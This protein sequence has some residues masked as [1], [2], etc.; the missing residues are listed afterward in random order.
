MFAR[1]IRAGSMFANCVGFSP[2]W[3]LR[4]VSVPNGSFRRSLRCGRPRARRVRA[5]DLSRVKHGVRGGV[6]PEG[7]EKQA[8]PGTGEW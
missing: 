8:V 4:G 2:I 1:A 6:E 7:P 3:A 5:S